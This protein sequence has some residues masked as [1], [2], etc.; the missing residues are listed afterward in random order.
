VI[1]DSAGDHR[2][3]NLVLECCGAENQRIEAFCRDIDL[4][5][6]ADDPLQIQWTPVFLRAFG[7]AMLIAPGPLD[8]G[9]TTFFAITPMPDD[10]SPE[11]KESS[12]RE[13]TD[14]MLRLLTIHEA[15]PGHY[16][17]GAYANRCPSIARA[18]FWSGVV[19]EVWSRYVTQVMMDV[20]YGADD[21]ALMLNHWKF[22]LRSATN[23]IID[24]R[25][26]T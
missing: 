22:Y 4:I 25:I 13:D 15:V 17:Q 6:L 9:L 23:A 19:A 10:W 2:W 1:A 3:A 16:L 8:R 24:N 21:P 12:L 11:R 26:H 18:V 20:G 14:R 7:G 5:G